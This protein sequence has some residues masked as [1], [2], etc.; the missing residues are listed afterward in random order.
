MALTRVYRAVLFI[1]SLIF[2]SG[3]PAFAQ[4]ITSGDVTGT[5]TDPTGA[6]VPNASLTLTN[7]ATN[8]AQQANTGA[9]GTYRFAFIQ[10]GTYKLDAKA[11]GFRDQQHTGVIVVAGQPTPVN[12]QFALAAGQQTV[13]VVE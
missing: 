9:D 13:D 7:I 10:P 12:I 11:S 4:S 2:L 6:V 5:V 3:T 1:S 8:T